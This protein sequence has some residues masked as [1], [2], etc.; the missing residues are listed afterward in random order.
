MEAFSDA[1]SD[2][3]GQWIV[4]PEDDNG[5]HT[6]DGKCNRLYPSSTY[7]VAYSYGFL[8]C[9]LPI[10]LILFS[11]QPHLVVTTFADGLLGQA[12][13][14]A[15]HGHFYSVDLT[16]QSRP[17]DDAAPSRP[18]QGMATMTTFRRV[19]NAEL[20]TP[21]VVELFSYNDFAT[22]PSESALLRFDAALRPT[23]AA[24][25]LTPLIPEL[26]LAGTLR[27]P[28][29]VPVMEPQQ[30]P[31]TVGPGSLWPPASYPFNG[32]LSKYKWYM[33]DAA[34][35]VCTC[36]AVAPH[37]SQAN[38]EMPVPSPAGSPS[39]QGSPLVS[40]DAYAVYDLH[41]SSPPTPTSSTCVS[42]PGSSGVSTSTSLE[43]SSAATTLPRKK[44]LCSAPYARPTASAQRSIQRSPMDPTD[45]V[46]RD[47][48]RKGI[49]QFVTD[50]PHA[51]EPCIG[52]PAAMDIVGSNP[53]LG[54][55]GKSIYTVFFFS[56]RSGRKPR[57]NCHDCPHT[58]ARFS[59][60][61]R[62]QRQEHFGHY[63]FPCQGGTSHPAW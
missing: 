46:A 41:Q 51:I 38:V 13:E 21:H 27:W 14:V 5:Q 19:F 33:K 60:G 26:Y 22:F 57:F 23:H 28:Y 62:H 50:H 3:F 24:E 61:L 49:Q 39:L 40:P 43:R 15:D 12:S 10:R 52:D 54:T 34:S 58:D 53:R 2:A 6:T 11:N 30:S 18:M 31:S 56:S 20:L 59:R 17:V 7:R 32:D 4:I 37:T 9:H 42:T 36:I 35:H 45:A 25:H 29:D 1:F 16:L 47:N 44:R 8:C 63:P 55:P 48:V